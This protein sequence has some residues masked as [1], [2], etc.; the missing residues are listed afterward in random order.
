[1]GIYAEKKNP[2]KDCFG[3]LVC[4]HCGDAV[5]CCN[6]LPNHTIRPED[7]SNQGELEQMDLK[8]H[9]NQ[10]SAGKKGSFEKRDW[11]DTKDLPKKGSSKWKIDGTRDAKKNKTGILIFVDLTNGTKKRVMS[12]RKGFTLDA[13]CDE[14]GTN[15]D[16]WT[17][18][19]ISL[20]RGGSEGQYINVSQ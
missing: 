15:S 19:T 13:F 12:L 17:G 10:N 11:L 5:M 2:E 14:L 6:V 4:P 9:V 7:V 18:K 3:L 16:K 20:E 8:G 1:M